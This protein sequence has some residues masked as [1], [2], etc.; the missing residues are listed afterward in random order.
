MRLAGRTIVL[1]GGSLGIGRAAASMSA[2][3]GARLVL[4]A[5]NLRGLEETRRDIGARGH[6]EPLVYALDV[7]DLAAVRAF[8]SWCAKLDPPPAGLVNCAG[9][10][11]PIG[12]TTEV[13]L[14]EF[15]KALEI[16]LLGTVYMCGLV[17]PLLRGAGRKKIVNF[18]GGGAAGPFPNFSAYAT[19]KAALVRFTENLALELAGREI[20]VNCIAPG[21]VKTRLHEDTLK[22][23]PEA[24]GASFYE[25][26]ASQLEK[27]GVPAE[28]AAALTVFLLSSESD[29]ITGKFISAPWDPWQSEEFR[30]ALRSDKDFCTLRR[31]DRKTFFDRPGAK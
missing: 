11:G 20:D 18:S 3:E 13:S 9:V 29:G 14:E 24:A 21:F 7:G 30:R 19:G 22:A 10:Y 25:S 31:I 12:K 6:P 8:A 16:N 5:R 1:T 23:G 28:K 4:V 2:A 27:G 17:A 15:R 26:T